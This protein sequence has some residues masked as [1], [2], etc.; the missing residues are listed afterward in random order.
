[1]VALLRLLYAV[2][3]SPKRQPKHFDLIL[4]LIHRLGDGTIV[5]VDEPTLRDLVDTLASH[6]GGGGNHIEL[7][8]I[9]CGSAAGK[10]VKFA[11]WLVRRDS[12]KLRVSLSPLLSF[13][14]DLTT[15]ALRPITFT[16]REPTCS[17]ATP[18]KSYIS[19]FSIFRN[20]CSQRH[21]NSAG[22][23]LAGIPPNSRARTCIDHDYRRIVFPMGQFI[24]IFRAHSV[25]RQ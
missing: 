7:V 8:W 9:A 19:L 20:P 13:E 5:D 4:D 11:E 17:L 6:G 16:P 14:L 21:S 1:V 3:T 18:L 22:R 24:A 2:D 10:D 25:R 23:Y 15:V 12:A